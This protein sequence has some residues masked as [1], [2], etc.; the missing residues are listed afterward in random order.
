ML[1]NITQEIW[2]SVGYGFK[3]TTN[4][5]IAYTWKREYYTCERRKIIEIH[6]VTAWNYFFFLKKKIVTSNCSN[7]INV[8]L[9]ILCIFR[10]PF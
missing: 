3:Y 6:H 8:D 5:I 4:I 9:K 7:K 2:A 1:N 10:L